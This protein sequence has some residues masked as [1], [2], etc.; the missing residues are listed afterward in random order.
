MHSQNQQ[1]SERHCKNEQDECCALDPPETLVFQV[2]SASMSPR[3][4]PGEYLEF[5]LH[6]QA[7][8]GDDVVVQLKSGVTFVRHLLSACEKRYEFQ[9]VRDAQRSSVCRA[10]VVSMFPVVGHYQE[11]G[12]IADLMNTPLDNSASHSSLDGT[13]DD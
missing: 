13:D 6:K 3:Y 12:E 9:A 11:M 10:A 2:R 5:A 1:K 7:Q 4:K 8:P